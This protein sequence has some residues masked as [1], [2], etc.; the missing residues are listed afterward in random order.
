MASTEEIHANAA[1]DDET[2]E[3]LKCHVN[4]IK[5][6]ETVILGQSVTICNLEAALQAKQ[7]ALDIMFAEIAR[8]ENLVEK[9]QTSL[10]SQQDISVMKNH[11]GCLLPVDDIWEEISHKVSN[12]DPY[13]R[14]SDCHKTR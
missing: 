3:E 12:T 8:L 14:D 7:N 6:Y 13:K 5:K 11:A 10:K 1:S 9:I 2:T 4:T